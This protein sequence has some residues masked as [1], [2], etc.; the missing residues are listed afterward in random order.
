MNKKI[1]CLRCSNDFEADAEQQFVYCTK[2]GAKLTKKSNPEKSTSTAAINH[3]A[4]SQMKK[5]NKNNKKQ[6]F[7][8]KTWFIILML[9][10]FT[11]LVLVLMWLYKKNWHNVIKI[12]LSIGFGLFFFFILLAIALPDDSSSQ[13][14]DSS[15][16]GQ[17][18]VQTY[19]DKT[20]NNDDVIKEQTEI[21]KTSN[22]TTLPSKLNE[23]TTTLKPKTETTTHTAT[24]K[25][26]TS[27]TKKTTNKS[28]TTTTKKTTT[29]IQVNTSL[30]FRRNEEATVSITGQPNTD[31]RITVYYKSGASSADG[32]GTKRSDSSGRVS[33]TW[34]IGG[35]TTPG[36][37]T[38][39]I[40]GGGQTIEKYFT[41]SD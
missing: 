1:R 41:V 33:W 17:S 34:H 16:E 36:T 24:I 9:F 8:T 3:T 40:S 31:Y 20:E 6:P 25:S 5:P 13:I 12:L 32:L 35:K 28:T 30:N 4:S 7:Y 23:R 10:F 18:I 29:S 11:P 15:A 27:T 22:K 37:Y 2:C 21:K 38:L 14:A 26:T 19:D 39:K